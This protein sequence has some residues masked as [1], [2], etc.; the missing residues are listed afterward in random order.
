MPAPILVLMFPRGVLLV[1]L[2]E[3]AVPSSSELAASKRVR[4]HQEPWR[5]RCSRAARAVGGCRW[6]GG[7]GSEEVRQWLGAPRSEQV[8]CT[9]DRCAQ[10]FFRVS[11][12]FG[13]TW[14]SS[15]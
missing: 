13:F 9:D 5:G 3:V 15:R 14:C 6:V 12:L 10:W 2:E 7:E 1:E 4:V 11:M 8:T